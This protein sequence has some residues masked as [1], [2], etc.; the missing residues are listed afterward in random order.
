V[1]DLDSTNFTP[2]KGSGYFEIKQSGNDVVLA[3]IPE[4]ATMALLALGGLG[5]L[6]GRRRPRRA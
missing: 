5:L 3:F 4:P 1:F 6:A 2:D